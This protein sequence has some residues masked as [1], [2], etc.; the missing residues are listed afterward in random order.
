[1]LYPLGLLYFAVL[2]QSQDA[3]LAQA[4]LRG[5]LFGLFAY[6]T[7]DLSNLATL[8]D[9]PVLVS[10]VDVVWGI[11]AS[12]LAALGGRLALDRF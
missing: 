7:Y 8:K 12:C 2:P 11:L 5:A 9:W 1:V 4:M 10:I 6:G 3:G